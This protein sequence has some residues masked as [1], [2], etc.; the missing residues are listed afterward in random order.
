MIEPKLLTER[1]LQ[2]LT[3]IATSAITGLAADGV[4]QLRAHIAALEQQ[5]DKWKRLAH[6][7][8][9]HLAEADEKLIA[10]VKQRDG[11]Q[12]A[13]IKITRNGFIDY[14]TPPLARTAAEE[15]P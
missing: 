15:E 10:L 6:T 7:A 5:L 11:L 14:L 1:E 12:A 3:E 2:A 8:E 13:L 4:L 9:A